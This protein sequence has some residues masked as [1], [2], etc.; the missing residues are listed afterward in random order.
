[1]AVWIHTETWMSITRDQLVDNIVYEV[2]YLLYKIT[3]QG[4]MDLR[5]PYIILCNT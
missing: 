1:M 4:Y 3:L 5:Y 2:L